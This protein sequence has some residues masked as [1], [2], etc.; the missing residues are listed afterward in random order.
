MK[1]FIAMLEDLWVAVTY[2]EAD[3]VYCPDEVHY[4]EP[5]CQD[6]VSIHTA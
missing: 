6:A 3:V 2:A 5:R 1:K 4:L